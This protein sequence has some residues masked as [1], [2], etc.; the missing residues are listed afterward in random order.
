MESG[1]S[2]AVVLVADDGE[3]FASGTFFGSEVLIECRMNA[4]VMRDDVGLVQITGDD[5][6]VSAEAE[7]PAA[8]DPETEDGQAE[9]PPVLATRVRSRFGPQVP[10]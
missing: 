6:E 3:K 1:E 5:G 8:I 9:G 4:A 2:F 10:Q 7:L